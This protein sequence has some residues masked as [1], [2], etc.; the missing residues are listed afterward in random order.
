MSFQRLKG[1][2]TG[3]TYRGAVKRQ[4]LLVVVGLVAVVVAAGELARAAAGPERNDIQD[5]LPAWS[6][7]GVDVAFQRTAPSRLPRV[8]DMAAGGTSVHPVADGQLRGFIPGTEHL[9]VQPDGAHTIVLPDT[10]KVA[11]PLAS[12][13]GVDA[14]AS[15]DGTRVA[16]LRDATLY[17]A[18]ADGSGERAV[19]TGIAPPSW[20]MTGPA[21][22]P[23]GSRI[24]IAGG[25]S[26]LLVQADGA[27]TRT[28]FTG[29]NQSVNP[30]WSHDGRVI[31]FERNFAAHWQIWIVSADGSAPAQLYLQTS[32][33]NFRFPQWSP[34]SDTLAF[35]S[36]K[37]HVRGGATQYQF[38]L[39]ARD[40]STARLTKLVDDVHPDSPPRWSPTAALIA[41][42]AGQECRRWGIYVIRPEV[43][44]RAHRRSN[45]CRFD[46][47]ATANRINGSQYFDLINGNGGNDVI[48]GRGG[49]DKISGENGD[50]TI[51]GGA[52][53]D[54][55]LGG[56][57]NDRIDG[58]SGNDVIIG[59]NGR[60]VINCGLGNDT[61]E[62]AGPLDRIAKNCEHVRR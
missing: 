3:Q 33:S 14:S 50:D 1:L 62:G 39:Y 37:Q 29:A 57:G 10:G 28:L 20:D 52:G 25:S 7:N 48:H 21:W 49:N 60:D 41:V 5:S 17:V 46:G 11:E 9:L 36:D 58:G 59:G 43:G 23:D 4:L 26:L 45:I 44:S 18:A 35:I 42:A 6:S 8:L 40:P 38:A 19:A 13:L 51:D 54:F 24:A 12:F 53:N 27:G 31:A 15:P 2:L 22:S 55:I 47:T 34:V 30:S 16:Y 61:V 56:P 32:S